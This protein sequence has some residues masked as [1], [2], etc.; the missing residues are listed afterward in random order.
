MGTALVILLALLSGA[1]LLA[2][3]LI[4]K[5]NGLVALGNRYKNAF[6]QIDIQLKR[7]YELISNLVEIANDNLQRERETLAPVVSARNL[8]YSA[9]A[10][11]AANPGE[12]KA[13][14]DLIGV[15]AGLNG[16]LGRLFTMVEAYPDL[17]TNQSMH[18]LSED[19]ASTENKISRARKAYNEAVMA[20]NTQRAVFPASIIAS[21]F[22]FPAA[23]PWQI[24]NAVEKETPKA[25]L[26]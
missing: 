26:T 10:K 4:G 13:M 1:G 5:Y 6:S 2:L 17:K 8:A 18:Q 15:E 24:R 12:P 3:F 25:S 9:S 16:A 21:V 22:H 20:Y 11:A 7:R 19:L 14:G 23:E